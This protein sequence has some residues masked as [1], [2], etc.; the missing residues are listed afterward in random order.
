MDAGGPDGFGYRYIDSNEPGGPTFQWNDIR[1]QGTEVSLGDDDAVTVSAP[2]GF[3]FYGTSRSDVKIG[4]NGYVTFGSSDGTVFSNEAIPN[5]SAPNPIVAPFWVDL[6]PDDAG[7]V[8]Y[9]RDTQNNRLVVQWTDVQYF[10][11]PGTANTFQVIL[12]GSGVIRYRYQSIDSHPQGD[13]QSIGIENDSGDDGLQVAY[14]NS[15]ATDNLEVRIA[16]LSPPQDLVGAGVPDGVQL[17]WSSSP[18]ASEYR[19]YRDT[20]PIPASDDPSSRTAIATVGSGTT[21]YT[22]TNTQDETTYYYRLTTV[23]S[24]GTESGFSSQ[25]AVTTGHAATALEPKSGTPGTR[26]QI[27]G[28]GFDPTI[29]NNTVWFGGTQATI[30]SAEPSILTVEVPTNASLSDVPVTVDTGPERDTVGTRF[31][32]LAE[33]TGTRTFVGTSLAGVSQSASAW[34]DYDNDGDQ[35]LVIAGGTTT[36]L[37]ENDGNGNFT[38][39]GLSLLGVGSGASVAWGDYNGDDYLDLVVTGSFSTTIYKNDTQGGLSSISTGLEGVNLGDAEW[40]DFDNDGDL[41]LIVTG[42]NSSEVATTTLYRNDGGDTFTQ[43]SSTGLPDLQNS[44][45]AWGDYNNDGRLDLAVAGLDGASTPTTEIYRN[46]G[47][48]TFT[49]VGAGLTGVQGGA[50]EWADYDDD[51]RLDLLVTGDQGSNVA[52]TVLYQNDGG[53]SFTPV[54]AGLTDLYSSDADWGDYD[55]DGDPDLILTGTTGSFRT[56]VLYRNDGMGAF[57]AVSNG[58][59][60]VSDGSV[61]W[62]DQDGD[63]VLDLVLTGTDPSNTASARIYESNAAPPPPPAGLSAT[64]YADSLELNWSPVGASDLTEYRIYR[65]TSAIDSLNYASATAL[66]TVSAGTTTFT[67]RSVTTGTQYY[68]RI[69]AADADSESG[70]SN[71]AIGTPTFRIAEFDPIS[72]TPT[73]AVRVYTNGVSTSGNTVAFVDTTGADR[74]ATVT[75]VQGAALTVEVPSGLAAPARIAVQR[76]DGTKDTTTARFTPIASSIGDRSFLS[77]GA[78]LTDLE[79][80]D[81]DWGDYDQDGDLDLLVTGTTDGANGGATTTIYQN[82]GG[83][84]FSPLSAGLT[85]V[86]NGSSDWGDFDGDG[87]LDVVITGRTASNTLT[88]AIYFNSAGSF[89]R[90]GAGLT[91]VEHSA[92]AWGDYDGDG[93]LDLVVTGRDGSGNETA[94]IYRNDG[95]GTF[96]PVEKGLTGVTNGTAD[97]GDFDGDGDLDLL[98]TGHDGSSRTATIYRNEGGDFSPINAGLTGVSFGSA[99]WGDYDQDGD[100]DLVVS[101]ESSSNPRSV[102]VYRNDGGGTFTPLDAGLTGVA[103]GSSEWGDYDGDGDLDLVVTGANDSNNAA[104]TIYRND[105]SDSFAVLRAGVSDVENSVARWGDYDADGALDLVVSGTTAGSRT[106]TLYQSRPEPRPPS[107]LTGVAG[108]NG[109][110][111]DWNGDN[112]SDLNNYLIYR[113][114]A[115]IDSAAGPA[116]LTALA[117]SDTSTYTDTNVSTGTTYYYRV[118]AVDAGTNESGYSNEVSKTPEFR[119]TSFQPTNGIPGTTVR[120]YSNGFDQTASNNTVSFVDT[121]GADLTATVTSVQERA[122]TVEVPSGLAAPARIAVQRSDGTTDTTA[123]RF[124]PV[125]SDIGDRSFASVGAGLNGFTGGTVGGDAAWGDY[126]QDG[127][128]D[129]V[130]VGTVSSGAESTTGTA[131]IYRNDGGGTFTP[132][133]AGLTGVKLSSV[134]WGDYDQDGDL[135]LVLSGEDNSFNPRTQIYRNDGNDTFTPVSAGLQNLREGDVAW[136]D[137]DGDGDQDLVVIG[138][139]DGLTRRSILY[140]NDGGG[141]FTAVP[142][143]FADVNR[144]TVEWG[145]YDSDGDLDLLLTGLNASGNEVATIYRNDEGAFTPVGAGLTGVSNGGADWGDFDND[146]DLDLA[147][148]GGADGTPDE[149]TILYRNDGNGTFTSIDAGLV[150]VKRSDVDWGDY[151][152]DG[153]LDILVAGQDQTGGVNTSVYRNEGGGTFN[154]VNAGLLGVEYSTVTWGDYNSDGALDPLV[155][156]PDN[157][158]NATATLYQSRPEPPAPSTLSAR[159]EEGQQV[160]LTWNASPTGDVAKYRIYRSTSS[161]TASQPSSLVPY[162][163]VSVSTTAFVDSTVAAN[164]RYYY[165]VSTVDT[166]T[167]ESDSFSPEANAVPK[168]AAGTLYV[169]QNATGAND[170]SSWGDAYVHLQDA[171]DSVNVNPATDYEIRVAEGTYYPDE[172]SDGDHTSDDPSESFRIEVDD[173]SLLGGYPSGGGTR[174]PEVHQT[175]L[176]GDIS[177]NDD[178][179]DDDGVI[180]SPLDINSPNART[181]LFLAGTGIQGEG[182]DS[183]TV[184]SGITITAGAATGSQQFSQVGSRKDGHESPTQFLAPGA[185]TGGGGFCSGIQEGGVCAP[186]FQTVTFQGNI[187]KVGGAFATVS[188]AGSLSAPSFRNVTFRANRADSTGGAVFLRTLEGGAE[189]GSVPRRVRPR[190]TRTVFQDNLAPSGGAVGATAGKE[191][192]VRPVF[193]NAIFRENQAAQRGGAV[194]VTGE[195]NGILRSVFINALFVGNQAGDEGGAAFVA[196]TGSETVVPRFLNATLV[197]NSADVVGGALYSENAAAPEVVNSILWGNEAGTGGSEVANNNATPVF[198]HSLVDGSGGSSGWDP[199]LGTDEGGNIDTTPLF[200]D[201]T[202]AGADFRLQEDSPVIDAG[203]NGAVPGDS[204]DLDLDGDSTETLPLGL[205][206][207]TRIS[208]DDGNGTATVNLGAYEDVGPDRT[209]LAVPA[210]PSITA[211]TDSLRVAWPAIADGDLAKYRIYRDTIAIDSTAG[212][213]SYVPYDS[214]G[215]DT[216]VLTDT[217]VVSDSTYHYRITSVDDSGNESSFSAE[218]QARPAAALTVWPGDTDNDGVVNQKDVLPLGFQWGQT[219]P[220]RDSTGC[221]FKGRAAA[222]WP[223]QPATYADANGDGT[224]DQNDVLC[225]GL[226]WG[227]STATV[228]AAPLYASV[229]KKDRMGAP[230]DGQQRP[231]S[232][233]PPGKRRQGAGR[234]D[235]RRDGGEEASNSGIAPTS[236]DAGRLVLSAPSEPDSVLWVEVRADDLPKVSGT[237]FEVAYP[238]SKVTVQKVELSDWFGDG[239][240]AQSHVSEERGTVG[241]GLVTPDSVRSGSGTIARLKVKL[242]EGITESVQLSLQNVRSGQTAGRIQ[243]LNTGTGVRLTRVP[244]TFKLHGNY[245]NPVQQRTTIRYD[246][247]SSRHVRLRV[248]DVLGRHVATLVDDTQ[249]AGQK[250]VTWETDRMASGMYLYRLTAGDESDTG[251]MTIVR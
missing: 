83:G 174:D 233:Q 51:G 138:M 201:T 214:V 27:Y 215:A 239:G 218:V 249:K 118:T 193:V 47:G 105:G 222:A 159:A 171:V 199:S 225:I 243:A 180:A 82:E 238:A 145:D 115:P 6:S 86:I 169:D 189:S 216:T 150:N 88:T 230:A 117:P 168:P 45:V 121:T 23:N 170:G 26:V 13:R 208:D 94:T 101:G 228:K 84:T 140:R 153:D 147:L 142:A 69:T 48:G 61:G 57:S 113:D 25:V 207:S 55:G 18:S 100:L 102:R 19:I 176:S 212:P 200:V 161:I 236:A 38:A 155:V 190:F 5:T 107:N 126:D 77:V 3:Q 184:I 167:V 124:V 76:S 217:S 146:G 111:L 203:L 108:A 166:T 71:Q 67:D 95:T 40:G 250:T 160:R 73:T 191:G 149:T 164:T 141:E 36:T 20:S 158:F 109:V 62:G 12:E 63:G 34:G 28:K 132:I 112:A 10:G 37:Y 185:L 9:W 244:E 205:A 119:L 91:G 240:L 22:D 11:E 104:T 135:D 137:Y 123:T 24:S 157:N 148:T 211:F 206:D 187:A 224:I 2:S 154:R 53:G 89:F 129:V 144:G 97:W 120:L 64:V 241:V 134:D 248:Y 172:D 165:R 96:V 4:S 210:A 60:G 242:S 72:G 128:L 30:T 139:D 247:P 80:G 7:T 92:S 192:R 163:S 31:K 186:R 98:I 87:D 54:G 183:N 21:Q 229:S 42:K 56:A 116:S 15:Y 220:A 50:V 122:L 41:D 235:V 35:D 59:D 68:Y 188:S 194:Y 127:D 125:Q 49:A 130:I 143:G 156:G 227:D 1:S 58:I 198:D 181:V 221:E 70:S 78:G 52:S 152:G 33:N 32:V 103:N 177:D 133:S 74:A 202:A 209:A 151:D 219:G 29:S 195:E 14:S 114:T 204:T 196:G 44:S 231:S 197:G 232:V 226:N 237:A 110:T 213:S 162:D 251:K 85:G 245:P 223:T 90:L 79:F 179:P 99:D 46:E 43:V 16:P 66:D 17:N 182:A 8:H 131:T 136:G 75:N 93:D 173:V 81:A 106:T 178:D 175:V 246:L 234:Q 39:A 65:S